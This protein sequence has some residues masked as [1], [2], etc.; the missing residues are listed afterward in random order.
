MLKRC[1][2]LIAWMVIA[3][4]SRNKTVWD[5]I[6]TEAQAARGREI[7]NSYCIGCHTADLK[8]LTGPHFI[9][10]W[11][12]E[13]LQYLFDGIKTTMPAEAPSSL[14]NQQYMDVLT[15]ILKKNGIPE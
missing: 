4:C 10:D 11:R 2:F 1:I 14:S 9:D 8:L 13:S 6:Y 5:G 15:F 3:G 12:E 7:Y